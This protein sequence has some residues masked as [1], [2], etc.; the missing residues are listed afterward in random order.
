MVHDFGRAVA[1]V[2]RIELSRPVAPMA[3]HAPTL[4]GAVTPPASGSKR[5]AG[6]SS[7]KLER[8]MLARARSW[9]GRC[10]A[11]GQAVQRLAHRRYSG[12]IV[13][14]ADGS[15]GSVRVRG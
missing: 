15:Q 8:L 9:Q 7:N 14:A 4:P 13:G 3:E 6:S 2:I 5:H 1:A 11:L 10:D 12:G